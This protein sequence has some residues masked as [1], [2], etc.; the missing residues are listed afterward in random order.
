MPTLSFEDTKGTCD[1]AYKADKGERY[2]FPDGIVWR[3]LEC[4]FDWTS[5]FR[6]IVIQPESGTKNVTVLA[7][8]G[9]D[10]ISIPD[11]L[12]DAKQALGGLPT[13]YQQAF[14]L[15]SSLKREYSN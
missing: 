4:V 1:L 15:T 13:Q 8:A 9:T 2:T 11:L 6:A 12:A 14:Q 10:P 7:F 5:G 3:V